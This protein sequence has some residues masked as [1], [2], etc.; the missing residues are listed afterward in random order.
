MLTLLDLA[1][2]VALLLW[3]VHMVQ[4]GVQKAYGP[5]LR[6]VLGT[7]LDKRLRAFAAGLGVTAVLQSST[8]TGLMASS[9]A[10]SGL[11]GLMPALA[12][13]LGANVGTTLIVQILSF[14]V[15]R[16]APL[17]ILAG[18][19]LFRRRG[20][21]ARLRDLGRVAIGLGLM[22]MALHQLLEIL[23]PYEDSP[24]LRTMLGLI[25]TD[26]VIDVVAAAIVTWAAHSSVAVVLLVMSLAE[27]GVI[28]LHAALA[29]VIGANLGSALNPLL[30]GNTTGDPAGRRVAIGNL[31]NRVFGC[32]VALPLLGYV[33]PWLVQVEPVLSRAVADFH[34]AFNLVLAILFL[35]LLGPLSRLL[36]RLLPDRIDAADPSR[37]LHLDES[38][39][40]TPPIALGLAA[41][42][43]LRMA[44]V[45]DAMLKGAADAIERGDRTRIAETRRMDDVLDSLNDAIKAYV[46]SIDSDLM[47]PV[48]HARAA[49]VLAF[50]VNLEHAGDIVDRNVMAA[51]AKRLK[52]GIA[53]SEEGRA[54]LREMLD[55]L[56]TNLRAATSVFMT[57]DARAARILADEKATFRDIEAGA[58]RSHFA[59]LRD[60]R[61]AS[62]ET[63]AAH[64][65][66]LR[67]L[68]RVNDH[69]VAGAAYPVLQGQ[70]ELLASRIRGPAEEAEEAS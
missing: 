34:T 20:G 62:A 13:M 47:A 9:F 55:R 35:P 32:I 26:P 16:I 44:D 59:R 11:V 31:V 53:F 41:R 70:G 12:V 24:S 43:A 54:E 57:D 61:L 33:G 39:R 4:S 66:L 45:L 63:N 40:E 27:K 52:K 5:S 58:M 10:A 30:E 3:G 56:E 29:L 1:G 46:A 17:L 19:I 6:R 37:P 38:A 67:D 22:L 64:L 48:D 49:S 18:V 15:A 25:A 50:S 51:A 14:D 60:G 69:L 2:M 23:T 65:D 7:A 42:E 8:A 28:P 36:K 68:K 21:P